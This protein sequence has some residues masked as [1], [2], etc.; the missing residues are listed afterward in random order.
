MP[1]I[2]NYPLVDA[3][4]PPNILIQMTTSA[5]QFGAVDQIGEIAT[6]LGK[7]VGDLI[8][9]FVSPEETM[10]E[11]KF[12]DKL[13]GISSQYV[14]LSTEASKSAI[15]DLRCLKKRRVVIEKDA[16]IEQMKNGKKVR[17]SYEL[18]NLIEYKRSPVLSFAS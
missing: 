12:I 15:R 11:F 14:T 10:K 2:P 4:I 8:M 5:K 3:V 7:P 1:T 6:A 9:L 18:R 13:N 17:F 16:F